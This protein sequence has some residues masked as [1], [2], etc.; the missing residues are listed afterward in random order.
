[1]THDKDAGAVIDNGA[2]TARG[3]IDRRTLMVRGTAL[4]VGVVAAGALTRVGLAAQDDEA[5]PT[6]T[7]SAEEANAAIV[8]AANAFLDTLTEDELALVQ[9]DFSDTAQRQRW[10]NFPNGAFDRAGLM[11]GDMSEDAQTAWFPVLQATL[12][13]RGYQ[14]VIEEWNADDAL[15]GTGG[16][17]G[18]QFGTAY[19]FIAFIGE[20]SETDPWQLQFGG[21]HI[22]INATIQGSDISLTPSFIGVEPAEYTDAD[23]NTIRPL[24][25]IE[26][27]AFALLGSLDDEQLGAAVLGDSVIDLVLGPGQDGR[28]IEPEG[29]AGADMTDDQ[30]TTLLQL[31]GYYGELVNDAAATS[32]MADLEADVDDTYLAWYGSTEQGSP[33]YFR[34]SGPRVVIEYSPQGD[35]GQ[36]ASGPDYHVHGIY[37]DPENDYGTLFT[38][39]TVTS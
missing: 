39:V 14:R 2:Q 22:T 31:I 12:S 25:D 19:Y 8:S 3:G 1:M 29:L 35:R 30:R 28:T 36:L 20:P 37:R 23:G 9:F 10:S 27:T 6:G 5:T 11:W 18:A 32:R 21:H 17:G 4:G 38:G 34:V 33:A 16:G 15:A 7:L 24:A 13:E 26:D